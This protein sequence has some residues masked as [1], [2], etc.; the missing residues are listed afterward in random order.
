MDLREKLEEVGELEGVCR[1]RTLVGSG[2]GE[3]GDDR[4]ASTIH[5]VML[6]VKRKKEATVAGRLVAVHFYH[7]Q[8]VGLSLQ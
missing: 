5:D 7:R 1:E 8:W 4:R 3:G 6:R 2:D